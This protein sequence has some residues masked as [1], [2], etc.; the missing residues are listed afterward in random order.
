MGS[1]YFIKLS[2]YL[3]SITKINIT[4]LNCMRIGHRPPPLRMKS[5]SHA[6]NFLERSTSRC[7]N[8]NYFAR[9]VAK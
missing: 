8:Y 1:E 4:G 5:Q 9:L 2:I 3:C 6:N 7:S